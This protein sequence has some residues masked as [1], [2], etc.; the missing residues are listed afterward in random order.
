MVTSVSTDR[1]RRQRLQSKSHIQAPDLSIAMPNPELGALLS[2]A[3][4]R[5]RENYPLIFPCRCLA[6]RITGL[7]GEEI[8]S[9]KLFLLPQQMAGL[10]SPF[11][12]IKDEQFKHARDLKMKFYKDITTVSFVLVQ[13]LSPL[14]RVSVPVQFTPYNSLKVFDISKHTDP[15]VADVAGR[16]HRGSYCISLYAPWGAALTRC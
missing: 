2:S 8:P 13:L 7:E 3:E 16:G 4:Q 11:N 9:V 5:Q 12:L 1:G 6:C 15:G 14:P 10:R